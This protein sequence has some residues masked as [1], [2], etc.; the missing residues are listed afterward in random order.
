MPVGAQVGEVGG[1][2]GEQ[3]PDDG[4]QGV[5]DGDQGVPMSGSVAGPLGRMARSA[6]LV[7]GL[8]VNGHVEG[9]GLINPWK[10]G[11]L[12]LREPSL[13]RDGT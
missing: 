3:V 4:E 8:L 13:A 5:A 6:W 9:D 12:E 10:L 11:Q 7:P 1:G 2:V